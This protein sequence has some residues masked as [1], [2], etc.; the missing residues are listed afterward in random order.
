[1]IA[2][3]RKPTT[4]TPDLQTGNVKSA[5]RIPYVWS[6]DFET[7]TPEGLAQEAPAELFRQDAGRGK[8]S[9]TGGTQL[10]TP[11]GERYLFRLLNFSSFQADR[12]Q[13]QRPRIKSVRSSTDSVQTA[14]QS[15]RWARNLLIESNSRLVRG[16]ARKYART[17]E[18]FEE[19]VSEGNLIL[20]NAVEKFDVSRGFRF[21][22][23]AT[24]AIQHHLFRVLKRRQK[25]QSREF[26]SPPEL[27]ALQ[28]AHPVEEPA[29]EPHWGK[30]V[31][32]QFDQCLNARE[33]MILIQRFGLDGKPAATLQ[34]LAETVGLSKERV[35]QV[36][37]RAIEKLQRHLSQ[38]QVLTNL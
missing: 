19:L 37:M 21:S 3:V 24:H 31:V 16:L 20:I 23:Y 26:P 11:E 7:L 9:P 29:M 33:Q 30:I 36:Q 32:G 15:V 2:A 17:E 12:L 35:R 25:R 34:A 18:D 6:D 27:F 28:I 10:L 22:T 1:M 14:L 13:Q 8:S 38:T 5:A 4:S